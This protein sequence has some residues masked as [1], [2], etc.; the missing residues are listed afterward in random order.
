MRTEAILRQASTPPDKFAPRDAE[1]IE[2][3]R[4]EALERLY[5]LLDRQ[6]LPAR[7]RDE[8]WKLRVAVGNLAEVTA[9]VAERARRAG[10]SAL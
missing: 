4:Y 8:L 2:E 5:R 6:N 3:L 9:N 1:L 10:A 7:L